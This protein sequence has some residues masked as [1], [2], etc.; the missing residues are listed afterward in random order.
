MIVTPETHRLDVER[1]LRIPMAA[2]VTIPLS[3]DLRHSMH[4]GY[5]LYVCHSAF[6]EPRRDAPRVVQAIAKA[7]AKHL[8]TMPPFEVE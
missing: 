3:I 7:I 4:D 6:S 1:N 2:V 8:E 5:V